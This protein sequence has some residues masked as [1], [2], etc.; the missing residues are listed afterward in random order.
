MDLE[1]FFDVVNQSKMIEIISRTVKDGRVISLINKYFKAGVVVDK[2]FEETDIG[3]AQGGNISP[4]FS[5]IM[6]NELDKELE[7]RGIVCKIR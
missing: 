4:L 6:L 7:K 3:L 1:K 5:N 2:R